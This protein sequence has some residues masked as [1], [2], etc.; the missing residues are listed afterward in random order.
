MDLSSIGPLIQPESARRSP[1]GIEGPSGS[2]LETDGPRKAEGS[3]KAG[4][5]TFADLLKAVVSSEKT[6][7]Q[8]SEAYAVDP[9]E[10]LHETML[11]L[12]SADIHF[13]L[14]MTVRNKLLDAYREVMRM[15]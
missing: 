8:S 14:L 4:G 10:N 2:L 5:P 12:E 11:A 13:S 15:S 1:L 6:A 9:T 3:S 7:Q